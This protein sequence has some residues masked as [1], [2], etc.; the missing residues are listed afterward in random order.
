MVTVK[1]LLIV[2]TGAVISTFSLDLKAGNACLSGHLISSASLS[3]S[4]FLEGNSEQR[5][6]N[7][8]VVPP[9]AA[10]REAV[11]TSGDR[12]TYLATGKETNNQFTL[13]DFA[14]PPSAGATT[15]HLHNNEAESFYVLEGELT[16]QMGSPD[17][18]MVI[19]PGTYV[20]LPKGRYHGFQNRTTKPARTLSLM[21]PGGIENF[22]TAIGQPV[23]DRSAPIPPPRPVTPELIQQLK[24]I[25][26]QYGLEFL[27]PGVEPRPPAPGLLDFRVVPPGAPGRESAAIAGDLYTSLATPEETGGLYSLFD[28]LLPSQAGTGLLQSNER[29]DESFYVL[30]GE[31]AFRFQDQN[32]VASPGTFVYVPKN[33][34]FSFQNLGTTQ[35]RTLFFRTP[36]TIPEP[37]SWLGVL[38]FSTYLGASSVLKRKH[39]KQKLANL[40]KPL[41]R[42]AAKY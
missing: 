34:P 20:Y 21:T 42:N 39:K 1:K 25:T 27:F 9:N 6:Q 26:P 23:I 32:I 35:A 22:F 18:E 33:T 37:S 28:V 15:M 30:D 2:I 29:Q 14:V 4:A 31:V 3:S 38:G 36:T 17:Q 24:E 40:S 10:G 16:I 41:V 19:T 8:L 5:L 12:Y 13:F 11:Y 7:V